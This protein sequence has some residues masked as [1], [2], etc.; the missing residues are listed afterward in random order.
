MKII[1][2]RRASGAGR[3]CSVTEQADGHARCCVVEPL[4]GGHEHAVE[5]PRKQY[6]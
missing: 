6:V 2:Q 5:V 3:H 1:T 4:V